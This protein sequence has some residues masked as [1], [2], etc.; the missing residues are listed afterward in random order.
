M[1][2]QSKM[3][4]V[5]LDPTETFLKDHCP[6]GQPL[7]GTAMGVALMVAAA[8][9]HKAD[10][11]ARTVDVAHLEIFKPLVLDGTRDAPAADVYALAPVLGTPGADSCWLQSGRSE[12]HAVVHF[13]CN[14]RLNA[15]VLPER[16]EWVAPQPSSGPWVN[17]QQ[18]YAFFFHGA[19]F[20]VV[21]QAQ[22]QGDTM[23]ALLRDHLP[24][25]RP[26]SVDSLPLAPHWL[27]LCMQTAGLLDLA[28]NRRMMI[29]HRIER[30]E[31]YSNHQ[32]L[33]PTPLYAVA[34]ARP[35]PRPDSPAGFDIRLVDGS[36]K[37]HMAVSN[38]QTLPL[39][40]VV[41]RRKLITLAEQFTGL[42]GQPRTLSRPA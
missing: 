27:E 6:G 39:P 23:R 22:W 26:Q 8:N 37:L 17:H 5:A 9:R 30:I 2:G 13:K 32:H 14:V 35:S 11:P 34:R 33:E 38:Y 10:E 15:P 7:L 41:D 25:L 20:Q 4:S 12:A 42:A 21:Q 24:P 29:P 40:F 16:S 3:L 1:P 19:G 31:V 36:G 28:K 18:V